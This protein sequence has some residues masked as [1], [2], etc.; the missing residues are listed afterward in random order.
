[1]RGLPPRVVQL[2]D[3]LY[4]RECVSC[5]APIKEPLENGLCWD[6]RSGSTP[7]GPP[8][9]EVC[10]MK[11][12]GRVDHMFIC[13]DC[14]EDPPVYTKAR[15]LYAY[16]GGIREAIH[17][18]K[19]QRDFS[20]VP[21]LARVLQAGV[22]AHFVQEGPVHLCPVPL[23]RAKKRK[24]GFNQAEELV[25]AMC[26]LDHEFQMWRGIQRVKN[27]ETQTH[28]SKAGR[29]E[30]VRG[31]FGLR[32]RMPTVPEQVILVDDVMTTGAT[33]QAAARAVKQAGAQQVMTLTV[34]RG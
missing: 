18:L 17:A 4:P 6:C 20:V 13:A 9:C 14:R 1:M 19:Y 16:E 5:L 2:L 15:S 10:G 7:L 3:V 28:L 29:R 27:T 21:D 34:A 12:A 26:R 30:N 22:R 31:A 11:I 33:L 25:R 32:K 8:W 24:R 23:H